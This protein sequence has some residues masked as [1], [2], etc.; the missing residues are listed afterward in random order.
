M[1][2]GCGL[3]PEGGAGPPAAAAAYRWTGAYRVTYLLNRPPARPSARDCR[4]HQSDG[5]LSWWGFIP[6]QPVGQVCLRM[7]SPDERNSELNRS[8]QRPRRKRQSGGIFVR[9]YPIRKFR[10]GASLIKEY[11]FAIFMSGVLARHK[12]A[13]HY[14]NFPDFINQ[15]LN[16]SSSRSLRASVQ[17]PLSLF[18]VFVLQDT[19]RAL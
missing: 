11:R 1:V 10:H 16:P 7:T 2:V 9:E 18:H 13:K 3:L 6:Q 4:P 5:A 12:I 17:T 8:S 14:L 15:W 19:R